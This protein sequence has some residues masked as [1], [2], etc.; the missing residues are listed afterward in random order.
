[1]K[2]ALKLVLVVAVSVTSLPVLAQDRAVAAGAKPGPQKV[3]TVD[4]KVHQQMVKT[5]QERPSTVVWAFPE[6]VLVVGV[7]PVRSADQ[8]AARA[9]AG[10][11]SASREPRAIPLEFARPRA[12][13]PASVV[14]TLELT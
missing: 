4:P 7:A 14:A 8:V 11:P 1:M 6:R 10:A 3:M 5:A 12:A 2:N 13:S 9:A